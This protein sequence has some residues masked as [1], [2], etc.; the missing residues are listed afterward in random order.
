M[1]VSKFTF[2][3]AWHLSLPDPVTNLNTGISSLP[4]NEN[5]AGTNSIVRHKAPR[6]NLRSRRVS[7][8]LRSELSEPS[9]PLVVLTILNI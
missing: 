6:Y 5:Q 1:L 2:V 7:D 3:M 8:A 4:D 9:E